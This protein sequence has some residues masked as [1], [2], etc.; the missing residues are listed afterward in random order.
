ME[1]E[2]VN[3]KES[4]EGRGNYVKIIIISKHKET[5]KRNK[6]KKHPPKITYSKLEQKNQSMKTTYI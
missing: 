1:R 6:H 5:I 3:F 2:T 4:K